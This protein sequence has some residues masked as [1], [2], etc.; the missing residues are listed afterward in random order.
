LVR[1][2]YVVI[3]AGAVGTSVAYHLVKLGANSVAV[4]EQESVGTGTTSQSSGIL[5]T[6]Y[7]VKENVEL[8]RASWQI[9]KDFQAY[10]GEEDASC[11]LVKCGYLICARADEM[12][13]PLRASLEAQIA[14]GIEV[15]VLSSKEASALLPIARFDDAALIGFEPEAGFADPYLTATSFARSA[16]RLGAQVIQGT[17]VTGVVRSGRRITGVNTTTGRINCG[18]LVSA[19][20]VWTSELMRWLNLTVPLQPERHFVLAL[21]SDPGYTFKM[22][23]FKDLGSAGRLYYRSYGGN[24]MLVSEGRSGEALGVIDTGPAEVPLDHIV[25]VGEQVAKRFPAYGTA[26]LASSWS[27]IYDVTPDW[28]PVLGSVADYEGLIVAFGFSGHGFKLSPGVG[29]N[30]AQFALGQ[31]TDASLSPYSLDRFDRGT[32]LHG[33]YGAGAVS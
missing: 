26:E 2:D 27:G 3:G 13:P 10:L 18:M 24:Q 22:P 7:S 17:R 5:R 21:Q 12:L 9:F 8:A 32:L 11:G 23:V 19:Q 15:H 30:L 20:G 1:Y 31:P 16:R 33:R 4:L 28:N 14:V 25:G 29:K 6:H